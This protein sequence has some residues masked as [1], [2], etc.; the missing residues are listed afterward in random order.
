MRH[1]RALP[2]YTM[3]ETHFGMGASL[4]NGAVWVN[5]KSTGA[6]ERVFSTELGVSLVGGISVRYAGT[7]N[8]LHP[9]WFGDAHPTSTTSYIPL[10]AD[11][12]GG[13]SIHPAYQRRTFSIASGVGVSETTFVPLGR[14]APSGDRPLLYQA[15]ELDNTD[16]VVH[17]IRIVGFAL[18]RG[19]LDDDVAARFVPNLRALVAHNKSRPEAVRIFGL[20]QSPTMYGTSF[21]FGS[22]YDP[23]HVH[24][25]SNDTQACGDVLGCLQLD[26]V[27]QPGQRYPLC[28]VTGVFAHGEEDA[29]EAYRDQPEWKVALQD[30]VAYLQEILEASQVLTP[31]PQINRGVL[32]SKVNM[33]RVM[34]DYPQGRAFTNEPGVSSN[35]VC[36][37]AAWFVYGNDHFMPGFSRALLDRFAAAQYPNGKLPEFYDA[38]TGTVED[39]GLNIND[40]TPLFILAVNH[41]YRLTGDFHWLQAIYP[42][43]AKAARYIREQTDDRHLV[44][45]SARDPRGN[46]WAIAG[47]RN[48][49]PLYTLNGAVTEIN[50]EC[51][52][53]LRDAAHLAENLKTYPDDVVEFGKASDCIR[54]AM[55]DLLLN[56]DNGLYYLNIDADANTHTDV[57]GD[58]VFPVMFRVCDEE[59]GFRIIS[60]LNSPDFW[61]P[62]GLR[63]VSRNDPLYDPSTNVGLLGGVW[64]GLTWWYAFAAAHYHPE[65]MVE[66]LRSSFEHYADNPKVNNTVPGQFSEWFDGESLINRGM[67]LSPWEPPR[68]LWAAV[69]GVCGLMLTPSLPRVHPIVPVT[70]KWIALR[71]LPY[72]GNELTY[73]A[74]R[75]AGEFKI[76][77]TGEIESDHPVERYE[78]DVSGG[79]LLFSDNAAV[80]ALRRP[81]E[82][83]ILV[84]NVGPQ[85]TTVPLNIREIVETHA[86][87]E[88]ATYNSE[89]DAWES[90]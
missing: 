72:H 19:A 66:A 89:R 12:P 57:T 29:I 11:T 80:V 8:S 38:I 20:T 68:F 7:G 25:L 90:S 67:R 84:G 15:I 9:T 40:A 33:R 65:F 61:T 88:I 16:D 5:T 42:S 55:N 76:Y 85:T 23:S 45:C 3:P 78:E 70:W 26:V 87:Y 4:G 41:H 51:V 59:T 35:V 6:I 39:Y 56:P 13:F 2:I 79:I 64:P 28:F 43:V 50:A 31:D 32:W 63:T 49:M 18:L 69:E 81:G 34:S 30:S 27:L 62:A 37:D 48:V 14:P 52:A 74:T 83:I 60:R 73:F 77:A 17:E 53:A 82:T 46:V 54:T 22:V 24:P 71:R 47:W 86:A 75:E 36:R 10:G 44:F 58:E 1:P 21:D